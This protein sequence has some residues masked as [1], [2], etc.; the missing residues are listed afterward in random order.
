MGG[1]ILCTED[2]IHWATHTEDIT[3][4]GVLHTEDVAYRPVGFDGDGPR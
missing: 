1:C 3:Y 4:W 2:I